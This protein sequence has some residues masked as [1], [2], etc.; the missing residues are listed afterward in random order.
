MTNKP[1]SDLYAFLAA[2]V[3]ALAG[4][5]AYHGSFSGPFVFDD[6]HSVLQNPTIRHL[7]PPWDALR[8][9]RNGATV[10]GRPLVNLSLAVNYAVS[11]LEPWS[12]HAFN[13]AVH[14]LAGLALFG[15]VRRTV[16]RGQAPDIDPAKKGSMSSLDPILFAFA[17]AL[18]WTLHPLQTE[19]VTFISDR[20]ESLMGLFYL[21]TLYCFAR[22]VGKPI[23]L[24]LSVFFCFLGMAT[25]EVMVTAPLIVLLY[26]RTF[27]AG[28]FGAAWRSRRPFYLSLAATWI[29]LGSLVAAMGGNRGKAAGFGTFVTSWSYALTQCG[30]V[31]HYLRLALWPHPL[32]FDYGSGLVGGP[33]EVVRQA[34]FLLFLLAGTLVALRRRPVLGFIGA[35]FFLILAPSSSLV[36]LASQT[37]AEHRMYLPLAAVIVLAVWGIW[38]ATRSSTE[39]GQA[40][41][42]D[43]AKP[44]SLSRPDPFL[45]IVAALAVGLGF[46]T[47]RRNEVYRSEVSLWEDTAMRCPDSARAQYNLGVALDEAARRGEARDQYL[48]AV[49]LDPFYTDA[50]FRLADDLAGEGRVSEAIAHYDE[51]LLLNPGNP[52]VHRN[53]GKVLAAAGRSNEAAVQFAEA[54]RLAGAA[55]PADSQ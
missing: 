10:E 48:K 24:C 21:L 2:A 39:R 8:P 34:L 53:L 29:L 25:K 41:D 45:V 32:V 17:V 16:E 42:T 47:S 51:A 55:V 37:V 23:W 50:H 22:G 19:S 54:E 12:Y 52:E 3:I 46:L 31:V 36:P 7:A 5:A 1:R 43:P 26:D 28:T 9:P 20:A 15:L 35:W 18:L 14:L 44:G 33:G 38:R 11:G 27:V 4:L 6:I 30:A 40:S 13:L 49:Q